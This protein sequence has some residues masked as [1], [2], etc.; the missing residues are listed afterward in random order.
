MVDGPDESL[1]IEGPLLRPDR[2]LRVERLLR[3]FLKGCE[4]PRSERLLL[5]RLAGN[6]P[7]G[8]DGEAH[9]DAR[10]YRGLVEELCFTGV[11]PQAGPVVTLSDAIDVADAHHWVYRESGR[12]LSLPVNQT[13]FVKS[14]RFQLQAACRRYE[15]PGTAS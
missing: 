4:S 1:L 7:E 9:L 3:R 10:A 13:H 6:E 5:R 12:I 15:E 11:R 8:G 2:I 14:G